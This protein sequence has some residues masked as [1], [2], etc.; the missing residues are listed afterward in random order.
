[1]LG[2][3]IV[4]R[5]PTLFDAVGDFSAIVDTERLAHCLGDRRLPLAVIVL[6]SSMIAAISALPPSE[7][8][9]L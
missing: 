4:D 7:A 2:L 8:P 3:R 6:V 5:D 9:R 1:M